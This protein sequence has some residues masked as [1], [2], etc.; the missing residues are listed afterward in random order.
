MRSV[1]NFPCC[2][3]VLRLHKRIAVG[4]VVSFFPCA[5]EQFVWDS[6]YLCLASHDVLHSH[7]AF[8]LGKVS[9]LLVSLRSLPRVSESGLSCRVLFQACV[10]THAGTQTLVPTLGL[11]CSVAMWDLS[12]PTRVQTHIPCSARWTQPL[13]HQGRPLHYLLL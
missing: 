2:V 11:T 12:S 9:V 13:D 4:K 7:L 3:S 10:V 6:G 8:S 5:L 1:C